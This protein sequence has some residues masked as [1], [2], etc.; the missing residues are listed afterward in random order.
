MLKID[1][2]LV[3]FFLKNIGKNIDQQSINLLEKGIID[4]I[5][6]MNFIFEV[7]TYF[8][9]PFDMTLVNKENFYSI[10]TITNTLKKNYYES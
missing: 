5:D 9:R 4:S 2:K 1:N 3:E 8:K 7:E 6:I 10:D